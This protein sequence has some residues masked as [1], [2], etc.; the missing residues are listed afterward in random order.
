MTNRMSGIC[1]KLIYPSVNF[2]IYISLQTSSNMLSLIMGEGYLL[3]VINM[4]EL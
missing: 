2:I 4:I 3:I 1:I